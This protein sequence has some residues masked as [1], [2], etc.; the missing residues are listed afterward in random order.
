M[1]QVHSYSSLN[2]SYGKQLDILGRFIAFL[3]A[4]PKLS[5]TNAEQITGANWRPFD[6]ESSHKPPDHHGRSICIIN[7]YEES[8]E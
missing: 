7:H 3:P 6:H 5:R 2:A 4:S 1:Q 8:F